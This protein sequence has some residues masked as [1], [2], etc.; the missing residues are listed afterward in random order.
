M[1]EVRIT[2]GRRINKRKTR[3]K[4]RKKENWPGV[5]WAVAAL[6]N[7]V[8]FFRERIRSVSLDFHVD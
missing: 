5:Y 8:I 7:L 3:R 6:S 2:V 1:T 4:K